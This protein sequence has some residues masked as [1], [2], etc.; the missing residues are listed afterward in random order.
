MTTV[1]RIVLKRGEDTLSLRNEG[2]TDAELYDSKLCGGPAS[3]SCRR[4][5]SRRLYARK[6]RTQPRAGPGKVTYQVAVGPSSHVE[7]Y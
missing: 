2:N 1:G 4:L 5:P 3:E 6:T 7:Q